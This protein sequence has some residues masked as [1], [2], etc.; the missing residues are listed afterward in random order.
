VFNDP[1]LEKGIRAALN[2][3]EGDVTL[4]EAAALT[5][6][7]LGIP[8]QSPENMQ[9]KDVSALKH[10]VNLTNLGLQF[11]AITTSAIS[12]RLRGLRS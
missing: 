3:P 4:A 8:Y 7:E 5:E 2:K 11:H 10:F 1:V 6:L 12:L 9:I